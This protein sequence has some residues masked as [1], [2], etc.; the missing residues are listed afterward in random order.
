MDVLIGMLFVYVLFSLICSAVNEAI[1]S[2]FAWRAKNLETAI[3]NMLEDEHGEGGTN[4]AKE[5]YDNP[6]IRSLSRH[7]EKS[8]TRP[9]NF[10]RARRLPSYIPPRK[11]ALAFLDTVAPG[12]EDG[13]D[14]IAA[15]EGAV[16]KIDNP[17]V[18][19]NL[20]KVLKDVADTRDD[21]RGGVE[22]WF[23]DVIERA[24]GWYRRKVHVSLAII[25][26]LVAFGA[27]VDSLQI[28]TRLWQDDAVR[29]AIVTKAQAAVQSGQSGAS[30]AATDGAA[31]TTPVQAQQP[32]QSAP[33]VTKQKLEA[34]GQQVAE[35]KQLELPL[36]WS[37]ANRPGSFKDWASKI[38]GLLI[39]ATALSFGAPFWFDV[40][41]RV[42]NLRGTGEKIPTDQSEPK[43]KSD[44]GSGTA[45]P[46]EPA[47]G[48][49][50]VNLTE[51]VGAL[52]EA[53][54]RRDPGPPPP[55][56]RA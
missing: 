37:A 18:K 41:G 10:K 26:V 42:A 20:S 29:D 19:Q 55:G 30:G 8:F 44:D 6:R 12:D 52:G 50:L 16:D 25:A 49:T 54:G 32:D 31:G 51:L 36:G 48:S 43:P 23:N 24:Q 11:F 53:F 7:P 4:L 47:G 39:T 33:D 9:G 34:V 56:R 38:A 45:A 13:H 22:Q 14:L 35:A 27:N 46:P 2:L 28:G 3:R 17:W 1:A 5:F 21:L 40:L 15:G